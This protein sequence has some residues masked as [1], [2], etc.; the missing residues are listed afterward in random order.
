MKR[1]LFAVAI[2]VGGA[3][4]WSYADYVLIR[5]ALGGNRQNPYNP[6]G[7]RA[8][9]GPGGPRGPGIPGRPGDHRRTRTAISPAPARWGTSIPRPS[10]CR[11]S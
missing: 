8:P 1:W 3:A 5:A 2:L 11:R 10:P 9:G 6:N 4:S 7:T